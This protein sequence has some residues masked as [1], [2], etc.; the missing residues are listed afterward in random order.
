MRTLPLRLQCAYVASFCYGVLQF[1]IPK[2]AATLFSA[3]KKMLGPDAR[4]LHLVN[5]TFRCDIRPSDPARSRM[6]SVHRC[7]VAFL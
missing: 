1:R 3:K 2:F 5:A 4:T 7:A 6:D